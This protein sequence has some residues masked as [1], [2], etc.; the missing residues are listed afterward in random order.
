MTDLEKRTLEMF[1]RV[2][3]FGTTH[4]GA[5]PADS[6]ARELFDNIGNIV[7]DLERL[8]A[9]QSSGRAAV[10][11]HTAGKAAARA[12]LL[13]ILTIISRTARVMALTMPALEGKFQLPSRMNDQAL[14]DTARAFL[15]DA[16][17]FKA[18]FLRFEVPEHIF[19][20]L[21]TQTAAF[22]A[23]L[24][25]QY[26]AGE[27]SLTAATSFDEG[28]ERGTNYL[29]QLDA[30]VRNKLRN[31][32]VGLAAW[33]RAR[34]LERARHRSNNDAPPEPAPEG[35]APAPDADGQPDN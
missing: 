11:Q 14:L 33:E 29:R 23:A 28:I 5:F 32:P 17:P 31:D 9:E 18:A 6:L 24:V 4:E 10:R 7:K 25:G 19:Q 27:S 21:E 22:Q 3:N 26:E 2:R 8:A 16:Q 30:V 20:D 13:K 34:R 12:A 1:R 15:A 35:E